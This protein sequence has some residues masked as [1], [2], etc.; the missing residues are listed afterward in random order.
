[1]QP[2]GQGLIGKLLFVTS[3]F[4]IPLLRSPCSCASTGTSIDSLQEQRQLLFDGFGAERGSN[5][6]SAMGHSVW[7]GPAAAFSVCDT[8][9]AQWPGWAGGPGATASEHCWRN[10]PSPASWRPEHAG[11][12]GPQ[13][14]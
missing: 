3:G 7:K 5:L 13:W 8:G 6:T 4:Q 2:S 1:M 12:G 9:P 11:P 14:R 10:M